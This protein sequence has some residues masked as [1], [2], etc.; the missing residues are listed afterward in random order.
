MKEILF[1]SCLIYILL[2]PFVSAIPL[3]LPR[4]AEGW[5]IFTPSPDSRILYISNDGNDG[6]GQYYLPSDPEI[7]L[8]PFNPVGPIEAY[9]TYAAAYTQTREGYPDWIL[10]RRGD[11]FYETIG[12]QIRN[13]RD[14]DEPFLIASYG[15]SGLSPLFKTGSSSAFSWC[16]DYINWIALSGISFYAHTRDPDNIAEYVSGDGSNGMGFTLYGHSQG[17][18][19]EGCKFRFFAS[20]VIQAAGEGTMDGVVLRRN[21]LLDN[22]D[23]DAHSQGI[24][25]HGLTGISFDENI[26]D[27][28]GWYMQQIV[29]GANDQSNGQATMYNHNIYC[30]ENS[31]VQIHDN[32]F[33]QP[34]SNNNKFTSVGSSTNISVLN[35]LY[36]DGEI[37]IGIGGNTPGPLRFHNVTVED[38][39][40]TNF[41]RSQPTNRNIVWLFNIQD[42]DGGNANDNYFINQPFAD[43]TNNYAIY[44]EGTSRNVNISY[45]TIYNLRNSRGIIFSDSQGNNVTNMVMTH[46]KIQIPLDASY[47]VDA[48]YDPIGKWEIADNIYHHNDVDRFRLQG[49]PMSFSEW[50]TQTGD[51]SVFQEFMFFDATR[52]IETYQASLGKTATIDAFI[53]EARSQDRYNWNINYTAP[54]V[55]AWIK[56]G[57]MDASAFQSC[58][59]LGG[60]CCSSGQSCTNGSFLSSSDCGNLCCLDGVCEFVCLGTDTSCGIHPNCTDCNAQDACIGDTYQDYYCSGTDCISSSDDCTDCSCNCGG[61]NTQETLFINNCDDGVDNDCDGNADNSD[62][63]CQCVTSTSFF[64]NKQF[65]RQTGTFTAEFNATPNTDNMD[66]VMALS[67]GAGSVYN[68]YAVLVRFNDSGYIEARNADL[69]R[70]DI[71]LAY[72]SGNNYHFMLEIDI[73][74]HVYDV[75]VTPKDSSKTKIATGYAFR[76]TQ[77]DVSEL[78]NWGLI[79]S[80][81]SQEFC[82]FTIVG[83][84]YHRSDTNQNGCI[85]TGE[86]I[87]F[88]DRW[89]TSSVDVPMPELMESIGLWKSGTGCS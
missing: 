4:D 60:I 83:E 68:D 23:T 78:N 42:W 64:Q 38:N 77:S 40:L 5:T 34:S 7:G 9:A 31:N 72:S 80:L 63:D 14:E 76:S 18:L 82:N 16:C 10:V 44:V 29:P 70:S 57:F 79:S 45:N 89:K 88:M 87:A 51:N 73:P 19:I 27:H 74:N 58:T 26:F 24:Y 30:S 65:T 17:L 55:N 53:A 41:G 54:V 69:Y 13:G 1:N 75:Y 15:N 32:I 6:S 62:P 2:F 66:G 3:D 35:N 39:V 71:S 59:D 52:G 56:Q 20:N 8:D 43:R 49:T 85:E 33:L 50:Q 22:Y 86:M 28:N 12:S 37:G 11:T 67:S 21:V 81:G 46:N 84:A 25:F 36:V 47:L 48:Y 61:Y